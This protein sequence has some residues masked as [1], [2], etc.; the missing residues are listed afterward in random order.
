MFFLVFN[1][2]RFV[3]MDNEGFFEP[4]KQSV[5]L[6]VDGLVIGN[7]VDLQNLGLRVVE[8]TELERQ[9]H[10]VMNGVIQDKKGREYHHG[11]ATPPVWVNIQESEYLI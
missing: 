6:S 4:R 11:E 1:Y 2:W 3:K 7:S 5:Y 9:R 8:P 10:S